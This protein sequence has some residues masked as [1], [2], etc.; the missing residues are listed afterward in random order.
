MSA[1]AEFCETHVMDGEEFVCARA[2][3]LG[4]PLEELADNPSLG[5]LPGA[6]ICWQCLGHYLDRQASS[7]CSGPTERSNPA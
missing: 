3:L 4:V 7:S 2:V 5:A 6:F 1:R